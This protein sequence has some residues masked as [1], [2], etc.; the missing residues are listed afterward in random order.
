MKKTIFALGTLLMCFGVNAQWKKIKGNGEETTITREV[1]NYDEISISGWFDVQLVAGTEGAITLKG[2]E[3]LLPYLITEVENGNLKV[4]VKKGVNLRPSNWKGGIIVTIP[5]VEISGVAMSGSGDVFGDLILKSNSFKT[6][7][8]GSGNLNLTLET[9]E[10]KTNMSGS[11]DIV[12]KG[13]ATDYEINLSGSGDVNAYDLEA[14]FVNVNI[15]G[16]AVARVYA[17][18]SIKARISGSGDVTY[19]GNPKKIDTKV[20]GSGS[21]NSY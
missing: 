9:N 13:K 14:D 7:M 11:G 3:N 19:K 17:A 5:V 21:I 16:S 1:G 6:S 8:S 10:L 18:S 15:S 2:E 12:L 20:S 4:K